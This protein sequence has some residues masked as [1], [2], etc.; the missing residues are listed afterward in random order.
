MRP[1]NLCCIGTKAM[2][3]GPRGHQEVLHVPGQALPC[4]Q[5][6]VRGDAII[7]VKK[8]C[9]REH[10]VTCQKE[11]TWRG[12]VRGVS[13]KLQEEERERRQNYIPEVSVLGQETMAVGP[14]TEEMLTVLDLGSL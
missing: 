6:R 4:Q 1:T 7:P 11:Q 14:D 8:L 10:P 9:K 3:N 13:T 5:M 2:K 12:P